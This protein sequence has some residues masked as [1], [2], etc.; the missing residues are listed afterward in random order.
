MA[1][2]RSQLN[3]DVEPVAFRCLAVDDPAN[4]EGCKG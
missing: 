3:H 1:K 2:T 4:G